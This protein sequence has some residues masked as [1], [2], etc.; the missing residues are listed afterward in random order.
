[1]NEDKNKAEILD[2]TL[3]DGSYANHFQ[4]TALD[5]KNICTGLEKAGIKRIEVGV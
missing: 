1:M 4:F 3:R 2:C 5:T